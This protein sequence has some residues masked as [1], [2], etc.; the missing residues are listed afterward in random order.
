[1]TAKSSL[2]SGHHLTMVYPGLLKARIASSGNLL[3]ELSAK[4]G[5]FLH[6]FLGNALF[7]RFMANGAISFEL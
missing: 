7:T 2:S 1:M 4:T 3:T 6:T 5:D